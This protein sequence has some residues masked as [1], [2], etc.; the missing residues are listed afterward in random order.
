MKILTIISIFWTWQFWKYV[1]ILMILGTALCATLIWWANKV[2]I[3]AAESRIYDHISDMPLNKSDKSVAL[4]FGCAEKI[5]N[6]DNLY[7]KYR[8]EAAADLWQTDKIRGFIVSGD[9]GSDDYNEP[10]D[11]KKSLIEKGVPAENI[12]CDY[13]GF[14]T[15]DSVI[16]LKEVFDVTKV[17]FVTQRFHNERA[18]YLAERAGIDFIGLN[19]KDVSGEAAQKTNLRERLARVKMLLDCLISKSPKFLGKKEQLGF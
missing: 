9:N 1:L 6:R 17:V 7:F 2:A 13:A 8:M 12:V 4:V 10:E 19:A 14:R 11:M 15:L 16:R 5:G 3:K 18:A